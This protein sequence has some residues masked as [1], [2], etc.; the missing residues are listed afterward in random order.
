MEETLDALSKGQLR[1]GP[2]TFADRV[3]ANELDVAAT[4]TERHYEQLMFR[5]ALKSGWYDLQNARDEY[6]VSCGAAG[7]HADLARRFIESQI[8][9][10]TPVGERKRGN[11]PGNWP[12]LRRLLDQARD[13]P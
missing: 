10:L 8:L 13:A 2:P 11:G 6:R 5:E 1:S 12:D 3:F 7:M 4:E 9:L